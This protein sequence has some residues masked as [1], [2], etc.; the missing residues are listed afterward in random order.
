MKSRYSVF[1][2]LDCEISIRKKN[3]C[4]QNWRLHALVETTLDLYSLH[5]PTALH[6][7]QS[8]AQ[9]YNEL[10]PV[11]TQFAEPVFQV[12]LVP[13]LNLRLVHFPGILVPLVSLVFWS[14]YLV[15]GVLVSMYSA[16]CTLMSVP[17]LCGASLHGIFVS[18][19]SGIHSAFDSG[20]PSTPVLCG[21]SGASGVSIVPMHTSCIISVLYI[22]IVTY[23]ATNIPLK[24]IMAC[25][26]WKGLLARP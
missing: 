21:T 5:T 1:L 25:S 11:A 12:P 18:W 15:P 2:Q 14:H 7:L 6:G 8:N 4:E 23:I 13:L 22:I 3:L 17:V 19:C 10:L 9:T 16:S 24:Y 26:V 20:I